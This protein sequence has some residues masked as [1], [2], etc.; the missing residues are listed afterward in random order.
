MTEEQ[1]A[2]ARRAIAC[3]LWG[4]MEGMLA[5]DGVA[6]AFRVAHD[7]ERM[8]MIPNV[9]NW[10]AMPLPP[11]GDILPVFTDPATVGCLLARLRTIYGKASLTTQ[12]RGKGRWWVG[13]YESNPSAFTLIAT[14]DGEVDAMVKA[15]EKTR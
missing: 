2:L 7:G 15:L 8:V 11:P 14:G 10:E 12:F 6:V 13:E 4:W 5:T 1:N 3:R 9:P